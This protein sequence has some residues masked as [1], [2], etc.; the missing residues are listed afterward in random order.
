MTEVIKKTQEEYNKETLQF[1]Q[2]ILIEN[3]NKIISN[4]LYNFNDKVYKLYPKCALTNKNI[5]LDILYLIPRNYENSII[6]N[7]FNGIIIEKK[8]KSLFEK[9][10]LIFNYFDISEYNNY[11]YRINT[12]IYDITKE[13]YKKYKTALVFKPSLYFILINMF[14]GIKKLYSAKLNLLKLD[15]YTKIIN[16]CDKII[17]KNLIEYNNCFNIDY[18]NNL[19]L[20]YNNDICMSDISVLDENIFSIIF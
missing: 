12:Y 15:I 14:E 2:N 17:E 1:L 4:N 10:E 3:T 20:Q 13:K 16:N 7:P 19:L 18:M 11:K 9:G 8:H 5:D 6:F